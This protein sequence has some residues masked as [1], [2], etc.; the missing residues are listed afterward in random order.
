M[1]TIDAYK[2]H[3][4]YKSDICVQCNSSVTCQLISVW[5]IGIKNPQLAP[6]IS[7][8]ALDVYLLL[9][10][11]YQQEHT[12]SLDEGRCLLTVYAFTYDV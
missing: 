2:M 3:Y 4:D 12:Q 11:W 7:S 1:Q 9:N 8:C 10:L 5:I 6:A